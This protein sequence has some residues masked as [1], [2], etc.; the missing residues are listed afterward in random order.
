MNECFTKL[1]IGLLPTNKL[2]EDCKTFDYGHVDVARRAGKDGRVADDVEVIATFRQHKVPLEYFKDEPI[3]ELIHEFN[4]LPKILLIEP[5]HIYNWHR[6]AYRATAFNLML[7]QDDQYLVM[8]AHEHKKDSFMP[9]DYIYFPYTN[10]NY[11]TNQ[12]YL[13]NTQIP[14]NSINYGTVTRYVL[15]M[16]YYE[17]NPLKTKGPITYDHYYSTINKLKEKNLVGN[18]SSNINN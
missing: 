12:F 9:R 6:D 3:L 18:A 17:L 15:S 11:E 4:L 14:H 13:L 2:F 8:F 5:G 1:N 10:L 7:T 16:G